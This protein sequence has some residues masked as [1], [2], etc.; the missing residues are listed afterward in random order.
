MAIEGGSC[1]RMTT[2]ARSRRAS[3]ATAPQECNQMRR[4]AANRDYG[5]ISAPTGLSP[6]ATC[7]FAFVN[8]CD[9]RRRH[10]AAAGRGARRASAI[11][12]CAALEMKERELL[13]RPTREA[14]GWYGGM[15]EAVQEMYLPVGARRRRADSRV[16][17]ARRRSRRAGR[18][19]PARRALE[20]HRAPQPHLAAAALRLLGVRHRLSRLRQERRRRCRARRSVYEDARVGWQWLV[21]H[22]PDRVAALHLRAFARRRGRDRPRRAGL[23]RRPTA[24]AA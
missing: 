10:C 5:V 2:G 7:T 18:A 20:P 22:E 24:R 12:G 16:V 14:A 4:R 19:L 21:E 17:V 11:G 23:R 13:F 9:D 15:P 3:A 6:S 8:R 1:G